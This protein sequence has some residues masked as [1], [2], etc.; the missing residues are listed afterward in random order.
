MP[1]FL[2]PDNQ[3]FIEAIDKAETYFREHR[4][5]IAAGDAERLN[6]LTDTLGVEITHEQL[7]ANAKVVD[8]QTPG[9]DGNRFYNYGTLSPQQRARLDEVLSPT[10]EDLLVALRAQ[11]GEVSA[12]SSQLES[13]THHRDA[14]IVAALDAG[15]TLAAVGE[16]I[17][18]SHQRVSQISKRARTQTT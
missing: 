4:E 1:I 2:T 3:A 12:L 13:A 18:I 16:A 15:T 14:L 17:G 7:T 8:P 11:H 6:Y 10:K 9:N 5:A